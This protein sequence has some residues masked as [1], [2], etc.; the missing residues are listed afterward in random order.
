MM[1]RLLAIYARLFQ[2]PSREYDRARARALGYMT[3]RTVSFLA[4]PG[5]SSIFSRTRVITDRGPNAEIRRDPLICIN[6]FKKSLK[7]D[8]RDNFF[9]PGSIFLERPAVQSSRTLLDGRAKNNGA[10]T[11]NKNTLTNVFF[12]A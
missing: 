4:L 8:A 2:L 11:E 10:Y 3:S 12:E 1:A 6:Q 7:V 9:M 5:I